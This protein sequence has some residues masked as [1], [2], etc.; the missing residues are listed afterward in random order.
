MT[1]NGIKTTLD[2]LRRIA[3]EHHASAQQ[4]VRTLPVGRQNAVSTV[5]RQ[6]DGAAPWKA[7]T[8]ALLALIDPVKFPPSRRTRRLAGFIHSLLD[9]NEQVPHHQT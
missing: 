1:R 2:Y 8:H 5:R 9:T 3:P 4:T 6:P 7:I